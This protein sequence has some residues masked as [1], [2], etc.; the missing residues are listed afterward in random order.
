MLQ[1]KISENDTT[2]IWVFYILL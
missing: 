1:R 2:L